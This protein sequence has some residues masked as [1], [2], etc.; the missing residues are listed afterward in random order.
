MIFTRDIMFSVSKLIYNI[1]TL[2]SPSARRLSLSPR[3]LYAWLYSDVTCRWMRR[4][5]VFE[6]KVSGAEVKFTLALNNVTSAAFCRNKKLRYA[7]RNSASARHFNVTRQM[8][9]QCHSWP[10]ISGVSDIKFLVSSLKVSNIIIATLKALKI[11]VIEKW[12]P[13]S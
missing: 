8:A 6:S 12:R 11:V 7:Q 4:W 2:F 13:L 1:T 3:T 10:S 9:I 5:R